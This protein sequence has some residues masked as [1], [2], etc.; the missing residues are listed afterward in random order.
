MVVQGQLGTKEMEANRSYGYRWNLLTGEG[1]YRRYRR[2]R[3]HQH[4]A[5]RLIMMDFLPT[6]YAFD[7]C[8]YVT[9]SSSTMIIDISAWDPSEDSTCEGGSG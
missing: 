3:V 8:H 6:L 2:R 5:N 9:P 4:V 1:K 7:W